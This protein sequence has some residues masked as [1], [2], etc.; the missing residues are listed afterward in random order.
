MHTRAQ[1]SN[2]THKCK[3]KRAQQQNERATAQEMR[4]NLSRTLRRCGRGVSKLWCAQVMLGMLLHAPR[5][6]FYSPKRPRSR[7]KL[8]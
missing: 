7:W 5:G 4:S 6:P 1:R 3:K 8:Y 2:Y